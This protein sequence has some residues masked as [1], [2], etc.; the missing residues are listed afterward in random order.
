[1]NRYAIALA[2]ILAAA[3]VNAEPASGLY[4]TASELARAT[5]EDLLQRWSALNE[6]CRGGAGD[7]SNTMKACDERNLVDRALT[8]KG[9][10]YVG[11][12]GSTMRWEKGPAQKWTRRG[13]NAICRF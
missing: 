10:C 1:M 2:I 5:L 9:Y 13:K 7:E 11:N 3:P 8:T 4:P 12:Y 6:S